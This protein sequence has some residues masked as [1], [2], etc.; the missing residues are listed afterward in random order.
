MK[1]ELALKTIDHPEANGRKPLAG[2]HEYPLRF[3][4]EDGR[5]LVLSIGEKGFQ[6]LTNLLMDM[7]SNANALLQATAII[8]KYFFTS[9]LSLL[10]WGY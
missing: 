2:E 1:I 8:L 10:W 6:T 7:L 3:P 9:H 5:E 4:L